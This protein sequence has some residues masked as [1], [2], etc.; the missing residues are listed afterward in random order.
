[1]G[2]IRRTYKRDDKGAITE[3]IVESTPDSPVTSAASPNMTALEMA[4]KTAQAVVDRAAPQIVKATTDAAEAAVL[5]IVEERVGPVLEAMKAAAGAMTET[6]KPRETWLSD[7]D[8]EGRTESEDA[9]K[10]R[11]TA[12]PAGSPSIDELFAKTAAKTA[13]AIAKI[14]EANTK[15]SE[16]L[17]DPQFVAGFR[18]LMHKRL[19]TVAKRAEAVATLKSVNKGRQEAGL[20]PFDFDVIAHWNPRLDD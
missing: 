16:Q 1:V 5:K 20:D 4:R 19:L 11:S 17:R 12:P 13:E 10:K 3:E 15:I 7:Y 9:R 8:A 6:A 2:T 14:A 18:S